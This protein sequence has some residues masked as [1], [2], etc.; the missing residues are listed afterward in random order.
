MDNSTSTTRRDAIARRT[1][2]W[3]FT[4]SE[5]A[6]EAISHLVDQ[7]CRQG[8]PQLLW[9]IRNDTF[10]ESEDDGSKYRIGWNHGTRH[11]AWML[12]GLDRN[13]I[14]RL[15]EATDDS[16]TSPDSSSTHVGNPAAGNGAGGGTCQG[17]GKVDAPGCK[18]GPN[19]DRQDTGAPRPVEFVGRAGSNPA[20]DTFAAGL[21]TQA[22]ADRVD[23]RQRRVDADRGSCCGRSDGD[24]PRGHL[25][26]VNAAPASGH[27][28]A[29]SAPTPTVAPRDGN[30]A[31]GGTFALGGLTPYG[32]CHC[33][34][35]A[36]D[37]RCD[38]HPTCDGCG[39]WLTSGVMFTTGSDR[40]CIECY[41]K[42]TD[43]PAVQ[44]A[45]PGVAMEWD[46]TD[47]GDDQ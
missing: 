47:V 20:P 45:A 37:F 12:L 8:L 11:S 27:E 33:S 44:A 21:S 5:D 10:D 17:G 22:E 38:V 35:E 36:G 23:Q 4:L 9:Q 34:H 13:E 32:R 43:A 15:I 24:A 3:L 31:G 46:M 41:R 18:P 14:E 16:S 1:A 26:S 40:L 25:G 19:N 7:L 39:A 30:K 2:A 6:N 29:L 28:P 42:R